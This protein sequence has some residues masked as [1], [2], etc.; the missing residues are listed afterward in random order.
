MIPEAFVVRGDVYKLVQHLLPLPL[1][2]TQGLRFEKL[3]EEWFD[4]NMAFP[5]VT[6]FYS[7]PQDKTSENYDAARMAEG[8]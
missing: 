3:P 5:T 4:Y 8:K 1:S 2:G 7:A 6:N